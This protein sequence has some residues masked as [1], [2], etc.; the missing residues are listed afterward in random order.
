MV[1]DHMDTSKESFLVHEKGTLILGGQSKTDFLRF[2]PEQQQNYSKF[3]ERICSKIGVG[4]Q[5]NW[6]GRTIHTST[7]PILDVSHE[8]F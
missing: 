1:V 7:I 3:L 6:S 8:H 5:K 2:C 4:L